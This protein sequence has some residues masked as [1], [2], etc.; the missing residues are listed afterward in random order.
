MLSVWKCKHRRN[1]FK[2]KLT[3]VNVFIFCQC[4][5]F[6]DINDKHIASTRFLN[7]V[8]YKVV[9]SF[10]YNGESSP[11]L[12][13]RKLR[14]CST[15]TEEFCMEIGPNY[16]EHQSRLINGGELRP[17]VN[18]CEHS[19][20]GLEAHSTVTG[21]RCRARRWSRPAQVQAS[22]LSCHGQLCPVWVPW[23]SHVGSFWPTVWLCVWHSGASFNSLGC[24]EMWRIKTHAL[25]F[26]H[27]SPSSLTLP[28][29]LSHWIQ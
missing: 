26:P 29:F 4:C 5:F 18:Q 14:E 1:F 15:L 9:R 21:R 28:G 25:P 10:Y 12:S 27:S 8:E 11:Q 23:N 24:Q 17:Y 20:Q 22:H 19:W 7:I 6:H 3:K 16:A 2:V 13:L